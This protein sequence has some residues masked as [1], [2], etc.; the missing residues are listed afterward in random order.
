VSFADPSAE[1]AQLPEGQGEEASGSSPWETYLDR[2]PE[3]ARDVATEAFREMEAN[4]NKKFE[5]HAEFR[6]QW[7][8]LQETGINQ[9]SPEEVSWLVQFRQAL[10]QPDVMQ[11]WWE[12]YAKENG[13]TVAEAQAQAADDDF[14]FQDPSQQ[15]EKLLEER[16]APL[17]K[18]LEEYDGRFQ[19][20]TQ[21]QQQAEATQY[22]DGQIGALEKEHNE[23]NKFDDETK[24]LIELFAQKYVDSDAMNAIPRGYA[25]LQ[26]LLNTNEKKALQGKLNQPPPA[27]GG[28]VPDVNPPEHKRIDDPA[29]KN[30]ALEWMRNQNR[31]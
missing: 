31:A 30:A 27:E 22:I 25:D 21:A 26:H 7:E 13:L 4:A 9:L 10:E 29:V 19:Q 1:P 3:D 12:G 14:G 11:Q 16:M 23:G 18:K 15:M 8:P 6:K 28:G 2:I 24:G 17:M 20:Q 5:S